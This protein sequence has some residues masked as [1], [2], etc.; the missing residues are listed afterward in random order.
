MCG[1]VWG[2]DANRVAPDPVAANPV[3]KRI[4][5][6]IPNYRTYPTDG[7]YHSLTARQKFK[8]ARQ[9]VLDPGTFLMAGAIAGIGQLS[10][11]NPSF[12]QGAA[13]Y[14]RRY[15]TSYG[16]LAIGD[17][18]TTA[19]FP[20]MLHQDPRYF[21]KGSGSAVSRLGHA[22]EQIFW[23]RMDSGRYM[24]NFSEL[25]GNAA[26]AAISNAYYPDYRTA[27][28]TAQ[29][30]GIQVGLDV[31]GNVLKEFWPDLESRLHHSKKP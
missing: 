4:F 27:G 6:I 24:V 9:D 26:A 11:T 31:A 14:G 13:G 8:I 20:S 29:R 7:Q 10:N 23:T 12:G 19:I 1:A 16:D 21:R 28:D 17:F 2:Q 5:W 25:G 15:G 18:M 30:F 22:V 3:Q